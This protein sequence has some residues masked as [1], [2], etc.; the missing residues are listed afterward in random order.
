MPLEG[1]LRRVS[2]RQLLEMLT[3]S[4]HGGLIL[5]RRPGRTGAIWLRAGKIVHATSPGGRSPRLGEVLVG[6][7]VVD[8][9]GLAAAMTIQEHEGGRR[10]LGAILCED[11]AVPISEVHAAV[12]AQVRNAIEDLLA[13]RTGS[14]QFGP[15]RVRAVDPVAIDVASLGGARDEPASANNAAAPAAGDGVT[16]AARF[17][18]RPLVVAVGLDRV[19]EADLVSALSTAGFEVAPFRTGEEAWPLIEAESHA[20]Y[21]E[22]LVVADLWPASGR[23]HAMALVGRLQRAF[24]RVAVAALV[25]ARDLDAASEAYRHG[26]RSV[27]GK[28]GSRREPADSR[29]IVAALCAIASQV[30]RQAELEGGRWA[31]D[32]S[33]AHGMSP[34]G[35]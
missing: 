19:L 7:G 2:L 23:S 17:D 34:A 18:G 29:P 8:A 24:P 20:G 14:F 5:L 1:D 3:G 35:E 31:D 12:E 4:R 9:G 25:S 11:F 32:L 13:W 28:K 21:A 16:A 15:G 10:P 22:P 33:R 6:R 26:A 30:W 27:L